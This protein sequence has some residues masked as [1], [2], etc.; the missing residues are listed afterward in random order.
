[1]SLPARLAVL[2]VLLVLALGLRGA[3]AHAQREPVLVPEVSQSLIE[4]A[5]ASPARG[6]CFTAR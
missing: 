6:C 3:P 1:M 4:C 2:P 5:R